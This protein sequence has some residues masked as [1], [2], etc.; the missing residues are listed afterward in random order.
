MIYIYRIRSGSITRTAKQSTKSLD[1]FYITDMLLRTHKQ[2]KLPVNDDYI[3]NM[4][5]QCYMNMSRIINFSDEV[6]RLCLS[7]MN[8][9]LRKYFDVSKLKDDK[10]FESILRMDYNKTRFLLN[11]EIYNH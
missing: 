3:K 2:L 10:L 1:T 9:S 11:T 7:Y 6:K 5:F 4:Q 8:Y